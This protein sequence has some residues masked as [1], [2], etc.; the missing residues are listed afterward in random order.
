MEK[1]ENTIMLDWTTIQTECPES[2]V[3]GF[4]VTHGYWRVFPSSGEFSTDDILFYVNPDEIVYPSPIR[5]L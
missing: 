1:I 2:Q 5:D 3:S 4:Y